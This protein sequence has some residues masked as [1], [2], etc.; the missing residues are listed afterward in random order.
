M[1]PQ[2]KCRGQYDFAVPVARAIIDVTSRTLRSTR[3]RNGG[4]PASYARKAALNSGHR[5]KS[6]SPHLKKNLPL[7][8]SCAM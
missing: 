5:E 3:I 6:K 2:K 7:R 8:S 1:S 4:T